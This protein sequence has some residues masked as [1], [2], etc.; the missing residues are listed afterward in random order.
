MTAMYIVVRTIFYS[1]TFRK[2]CMD[3]YFCIYIHRLS[4]VKLDEH[5]HG[6]E[7][8][9]IFCFWQTVQG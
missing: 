5:V 1:S 3:E 6:D 4:V 7:C 8:L 2:H 9:S